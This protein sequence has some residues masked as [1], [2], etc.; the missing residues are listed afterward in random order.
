MDL[1]EKYMVLI[2][3]SF[4]TNDYIKI[5][6]IIAVIRLESGVKVAGSDH[7]ESSCIW[8]FRV[9]RPALFLMST[10][11]ITGNKE[12]LKKEQT[13][14]INHVE[15]K[16]EGWRY[17]HLPTI[18]QLYCSPM[19]ILTISSIC[20]KIILFE[21]FSMWETLIKRITLKIAFCKESK[22]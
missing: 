17:P 22:Y 10:V 7:Y 9:R 15:A 20:I 19:I 2:T 12:K 13:I 8:S 6:Y 1:W 14:L 3:L 5:C 21:E 11:L 16:T 4:H 18:A